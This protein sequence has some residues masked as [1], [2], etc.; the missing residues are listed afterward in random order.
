M[1]LPKI[2]I[3]YSQALL[4]A[5]LKYNLVHLTHFAR[6]SHD[7]LTRALRNRFPWKTIFLHF[8]L[9]HCLNNGYLIVDETDIDKSFAKAISGLAWIFSHRKN[10]YIFG[11]H[12]VVVVW[13]NGTITIPITWKLWQKSS[14]PSKQKTK[15]A[16][17]LEMIKFCTFI[18]N[19]KPH[20]WLFDAL[21]ASEPILKFLNNHSLNFFSQVPKNRKFNHQQLKFWY[22]N[23]P[24]WQDI[25]YIKG[26][27][28]VRVVKNRK[29]YFITN[30]TGIP[31]QKLLDTYKIRW[32]IEEVFR[33]V[34]SQLG[35]EKCQCRSIQ[36]QMNH[37]GVC[38]VLFVV[39]QDIAKKTGLTDY[40]I[41]EQATLDHSFV[42]SLNLSSYFDTA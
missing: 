19:I 14:D 11:Y 38:F 25:G 9:N 35:M 33:Y 27:I 3:S 29:K 7:Q 37:F 32:K 2:I 42:F 28:K 13:T 18:L 39:L 22:K 12:L 23:R 24:Y 31:R 34:K 4:S 26:K 1:L 40:Q 6:N 16:L 8:L 5:S 10:K 20:A 15:Q 36:A 41:K 30:V 17:A 21:Y